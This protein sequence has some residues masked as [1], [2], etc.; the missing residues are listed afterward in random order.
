MVFEKSV[1]SALNLSI[2]I[3][4]PTFLK[5]KKKKLKN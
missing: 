5:K 4:W 3:S 2:L 1:F